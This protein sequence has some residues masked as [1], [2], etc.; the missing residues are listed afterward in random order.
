MSVFTDSVP[1][2]LSQLRNF[3]GNHL[4]NALAF[5]IDQHQEMSARRKDLSQANG[6]VNDIQNKI[7]A[8][9]RMHHSF[10]YYLLSII[11]TVILLL[12]YYSKHSHNRSVGQLVTVLG[13]VIAVSLLEAGIAAIEYRLNNKKYLRFSAVLINICPLAILYIADLCYKAFPSAIGF[14]FWFSSDESDLLFFGGLITLVVMSYAG[15]EIAFAT[16]AGH[17]GRLLRA[18]LAGLIPISSK[19]VCQHYIPLYYDLLVIGFLTYFVWTLLP[20]FKKVETK[21]FKEQSHTEVEKKYADVLRAA[22]LEQE[23]K[24]Q[25]LKRFILT[26]GWKQVAYNMDIPK[27]YSSLQCLIKL[28]DIVNNAR[29]ETLSDATNIYEEDEY[30]ARVERSIQEQNR[31]IKEQNR[32]IAQAA[33]EVRYQAAEARKEQARYHRESERIQRDIS[34]SHRRTASATERLKDIEERRDEYW[35]I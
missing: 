21:E 35:G 22:K 18:W 28:Y 5:A 32:Q 13:F 29:A 7:T 12:H 4:A 25:E 1:Y 15:I 23:A 9:A 26:E 10:R 6:R 16:K 27:Q 31:L 20:Y 8:E 17:A 19:L 11:G 30:R 3:R 34:D 24:F 14:W 33:A 2:D